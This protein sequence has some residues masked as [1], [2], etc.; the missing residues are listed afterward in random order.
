MKINI[1]VKEN[2]RIVT[3]EFLK[4]DTRGLDSVNREPACEIHLTY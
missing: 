4:A 3:G 1:K 2:K